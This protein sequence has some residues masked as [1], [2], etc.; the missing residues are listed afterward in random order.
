MSEEDVLY[1]ILADMEAPISLHELRL[2]LQR[3]DFPKVSWEEA[4]RINESFD[5]NE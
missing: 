3:D 5:K 1:M 2:L 4:C